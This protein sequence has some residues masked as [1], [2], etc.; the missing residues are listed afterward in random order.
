[1][2]KRLTRRSAFTLIEV[3]VAVM[4]VSVVIAALLQ[5]QGNASN[6][7][8]QIKKIMQS[9]QYGSFLL[10]VSEKH[11]FEDSSSDIKTLLDDFELESDLRRK[12]KAMK[13][14]IEYE[15]LQIIDTNEILG[16]NDQNEQESTAGSGV[17]FEIGKTL[18][19]MEESSIELI[20]VRLQ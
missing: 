8:F 3:M 4:I 10:S 16:K 15:E 1:M 12:L 11:G 17:I 14:D 2:P 19:K 9:S 6:K 20:R 7:F 13:I 5:M 18:L